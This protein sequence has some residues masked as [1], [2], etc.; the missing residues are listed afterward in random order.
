M[1]K[2]VN[3]KTLHGLHYGFSINSSIKLGLHDGFTMALVKNRRVKS[4]I[5]FKKQFAFFG[6]FPW[7][8]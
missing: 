1:A 6:D 2:L 4:N 8:V 3:V 5:N 7:A